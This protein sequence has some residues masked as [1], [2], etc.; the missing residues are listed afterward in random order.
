MSTNNWQHIFRSPPLR[1]TSEMDDEEEEA[2]EAL[3]TF[4]TRMVLSV[5]SKLS[6]SSPRR[7]GE[8]HVEPRDEARSPPVPVPVPRPGAPERTEGD[9]IRFGK[10][11]VRVGGMAS[12][13][14]RDR[15]PLSG[16]PNK[17]GRCAGK[18]TSD[19]TSHNLSSQGPADQ[20]VPA[21]LVSLLR[22]KT[23]MQEMRRVRECCWGSLTFCGN[24]TQP[25]LAGPMTFLC[26][27]R[28]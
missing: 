10:H 21:R 6:N 8:Q 18:K 14:R 11:V 22:R 12:D 16:Q 5:R 3:R 4:C 27:M 24:E 7:E 26:V 17:R 28:P 13:H 25:T 2:E 23:L 1:N 19:L 15:V 9:R 20:L